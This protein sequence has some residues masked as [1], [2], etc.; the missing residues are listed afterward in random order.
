MEL[1]LAGGD[2]SLIDWVLLS[3]TGVS[4]NGKIITGFGIDPSGYTEAWVAHLSNVPLAAALPLF[5]TG[6]G[7]MGLVGWRRKR[8]S[9]A[10]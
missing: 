9:A 10:A 6:L 5:A 2:A 7:A 1:M 8:K 4:A 3:A